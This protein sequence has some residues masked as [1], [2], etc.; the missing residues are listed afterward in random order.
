MKKYLLW[1]ALSAAWLTAPTP[2]AHAQAGQIDLS[3]SLDGMATYDAGGMDERVEDVLLQPDGKILVAG[4]SYNGTEEDFVLLRYDADGTLDATFGIG[5]KVI[6]ANEGRDRFNSL[7]LQPDGKILMGGSFYWGMALYRFEPDGRPDSTFGVGGFAEKRFTGVTYC[8]DIVLQ[9]DGKVVAAGQTWPGSANQFVAVRFEVDG[10]IDSTFGTNGVAIAPYF[11]YSNCYAA[12]LQPDG[13]IL[14]AGTMGDYMA[15]ARLLPNGDLDSTFGDDG[16]ALGWTSGIAR[17]YGIGLQQDG[18]VVLC[19]SN[20]YFN[21]DYAVM[22]FTAGGDLDSTFGQGGLVVSDLFFLQSG[23]QDLQIQPDGKL[24]VVGSSVGGMTVVRYEVDGRIDSTFG[25]NGIAWTTFGSQNNVGK[26]VLLQPDGRI[27][28]G[29]YTEQ[30]QDF[31]FMVARFHNDGTLDVPEAGHGGLLSLAPNPSG[32][33]VRVGWPR[34]ARA[35]RLQVLDVSG[36]VVMT[37]DGLPG[38]ELAL[39]LSGLPGGMYLVRVVGAGG[40]WTAKVLRQ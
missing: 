25:T 40:S 34:A 23:A 38:N 6:A 5:G 35:V 20:H 27:V 21:G 11:S 16:I 19:G 26:T 31:D 8:Y 7:A 4:T 10:D 30:A 33:L 39:D 2:F 15:A 18:K 36:R 12:S 28:V 14:M 17:C 1:I 9:P 32:G 24:V 22:R 13:K 29:G 37:Q 3:F